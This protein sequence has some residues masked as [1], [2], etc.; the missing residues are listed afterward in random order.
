MIDVS[1]AKPVNGDLKQEFGRQMPRI[2]ALD[3]TQRL[4]AATIRDV[5]VGSFLAALS[6]GASSANIEAGF[7]KTGVIP[8]D[9]EAAL[10]SPYVEDVETE[11]TLVGNILQGNFELTSDQGLEFLARREFQCSA[12]EASAQWNDDPRVL[13][14]QWQ[15]RAPPSDQ[16]L[17][18]I[19]G[20]MV[21]FRG[22]FHP[23]GAA[24]PVEGNT[25][26]QMSWYA[27]RA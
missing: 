9:V 10:H 12:A 27:D 7:R 25:V 4:K 24:S 17:S 11:K 19:P 18:E 2:G 1:V 8:R 5:A 22:L 20:Y 3:P 15:A 14:Q 26:A 13:F 6:K 16:F 21:T 23:Q